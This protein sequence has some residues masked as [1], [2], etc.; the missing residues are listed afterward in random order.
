[1]HFQITQREFI[2]PNYSQF[3]LGKACLGIRVVVCL[4]EFIIE[5]GVYYILYS[6]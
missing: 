1:M 4:F 2:S 5:L 6:L 3:R